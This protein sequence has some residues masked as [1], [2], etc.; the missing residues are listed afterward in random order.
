[1]GSMLFFLPR[2]S[3]S[4]KGAKVQRSAKTAKKR[5]EPQGAQRRRKDR[6]QDQDSQDERISRIAAH[7]EETR[8]SLHRNPVDPFIL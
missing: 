3:V 5:T 8:I 7:T 6:Q 4:R 1:M 2:R